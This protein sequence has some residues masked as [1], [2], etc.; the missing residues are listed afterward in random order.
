MLC[1][2]IVDD[3]T[4]LRETLASI[5][6]TD[7]RGALAARSAFTIALAGGSVAAA[8][9][10]RLARAAVDWSAV[11]F[12]WV[13]ERAVLPTDPESNYAAA[14][15]LWLAPS[16]V[17]P[18][19]IHRMPADH[20]SLDVAA[21]EYAAEIVRTLGATPALDLALV[22]VGSDGHVASLF[23]GHA[24]LR[25]EHRHVAAVDDAPK[26][27]PRRLTLTL[28]ML[29]SAR[30]VVVAAMGGE[31]ASAI[32][33]S[34]QDPASPLPLA[35]LLRRATRVTML[36]DAEAAASLPHAHRR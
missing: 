27:P 13:D 29:A 22:G 14:R 25:E 19:R 20:P 35:R 1:E 6:E 16:A 21:A 5:L 4:N 17:P 8:F 7:A 36:L 34:V 2:P 3:M 23:P 10:P 11:D 9:F 31:K 15:S 18:E 33:E 30:H 12:F 24:L 26:P 32:A 28:P